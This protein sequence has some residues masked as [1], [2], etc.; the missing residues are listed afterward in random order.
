MLGFFNTEYIRKEMNATMNT[1]ETD[2]SAK[3]FLH[4]MALRSMLFLENFE[5]CIEQLEDKHIW[6]HE[7]K[8]DNAIGNLILHIIGNIQQVV[9]RLQGRPNKR[10]RNLEFTI[11]DGLSK[12]ELQNQLRMIVE[13][14]CHLLE[15][16]PKEKV[17]MEY[18]IMNTDTT[19]AY[20]LLM[21][22]THFSLHLGQIQFITKNI[23]QEKYTEAVRR[24]PK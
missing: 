14:Y 23:L 15:T 12:K 9:D 2:C 16:I 17:S 13:E 21:A 22:L 6:M 20:A 19:V 1:K 18:R 4:E 8:Y 5:Q 3:V 7:H 11:K 10:D 24:I